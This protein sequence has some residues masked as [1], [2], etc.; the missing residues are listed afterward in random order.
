M[1]LSSNLR[2]GLMG[3]DLSEEREKQGSSITAYP[4]SYVQDGLASMHNHAFMADPIFCEAYARGV[5]AGFMSSS[6][7]HYL[8]WNTLDRT[9]YLLDIFS[10]I[11]PRFV[12]EADLADGILEKNEK[13][14]EVGFYVDGLESVRNNFF[15]W[16]RCLRGK[17]C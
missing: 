10:G 9:F 16:H 2:T 17:G 5:N 4:G 12:S 7:M 1:R 15:E 11:D 6:V 3:S 13:L 14:K 8:K